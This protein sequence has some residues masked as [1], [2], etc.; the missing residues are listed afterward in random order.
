MSNESIHNN[1]GALVFQLVKL[2]VFGGEMW[3][4]NYFERPS[5]FSKLDQW[6]GVI[7][8]WNLKWNVNFDK[9]LFLF[10]FINQLNR[11]KGTCTRNYRSNLPFVIKPFNWNFWLLWWKCTLS[12]R[13]IRKEVLVYIK[14][15]SWCV[16]VIQF[17]V[18]NFSFLWNFLEGS[19]FSVVP[20]LLVQF[21]D[22]KTIRAQLSVHSRPPPN[23][24]NNFKMQKIQ[25]I[26]PIQ[27]LLLLST[28]FWYAV[29]C[30]YKSR[31][32]R[33]AKVLLALQIILIFL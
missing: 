9:H 22:F 17:N 13:D 21:K 12:S 7:V 29:K 3:K 20:F 32:C 6:F 30:S 31:I 15:K 14:N 2:L 1:Q 5:H 11:Q 10:T 33:S 16:I 8:T 26:N 24:F 23:F 28:T 25:N 18:W 27:S 19:T 4:D